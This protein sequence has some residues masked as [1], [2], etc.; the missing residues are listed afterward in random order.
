MEVVGAGAVAADVVDLAVEVDPGGEE[1]A[2]RIV[3]KNMDSLYWIVSIF[4]DFS[5]Q[6]FWIL[7][8]VDLYMDTSKD[9]RSDISYMVGGLQDHA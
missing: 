4:V 5:P 9:N 3:L 1:D 7:C 6:T 8:C 2:D